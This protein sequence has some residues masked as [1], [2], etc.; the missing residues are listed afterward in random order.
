M[1]T[2]VLIA[3]YAVIWAM[4]MVDVL[5]DVVFKPEVIKEWFGTT[6][7]LETGYWYKS[8][9]ILLAVGLLI[10]FWPIAIIY[11]VLKK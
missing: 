3:V 5:M 1:E 8:A 4:I 7:D 10:V 9:G 6:L 2:L 11:V